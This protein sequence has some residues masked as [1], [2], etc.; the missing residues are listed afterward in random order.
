MTTGHLE[1]HLQYEIKKYLA[2]GLRPDYKQELQLFDPNNLN[3]PDVKRLRELHELTREKLEKEFPSNGNKPPVL[4]KRPSTAGGQIP[5]STKAVSK[6]ELGHALWLIC[7]DCAEDFCTN[8][9]PKLREEGFLR[10]PNKDRTFMNEAMILHFWIIWRVVNNDRAVLDVLNNY[11]NGWDIQQTEARASEILP[12]RF[13][14]YDEAFQQEEEMFARGGLTPDKFASGARAALQ[15]LLNDGKP[16]K[17]NFSFV[18]LTEVHFSL[19]AT[20][21]TAHKFME[22]FKIRG[23]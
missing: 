9:M 13:A 21:Q 7:C 4:E 2:E 12:K 15:C 23:A 6:E 8:L 11:F 16:D 14:R 10:D 18:I 20:I 17:A 1:Q 22:E 19:S 5:N 3:D